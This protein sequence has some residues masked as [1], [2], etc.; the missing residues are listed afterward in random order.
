MVCVSFIAFFDTYFGVKFK[1]GS[2][3][4]SFDSS[5]IFNT[6]EYEKSEDNKK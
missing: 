5:F 3:E 2:Y 4:K 6:Q 1:Y